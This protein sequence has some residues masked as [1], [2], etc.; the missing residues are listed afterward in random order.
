MSIE[1]AYAALEIPP[2]TIDVQVSSADVVVGVATTVRA[3]SAAQTMGD[4]GQTANAS[5]VAAGTIEISHASLAVPEGANATRD[6]EAA[7]TM[8]DF[9][10]VASMFDPIGTID[11]GGTITDGLPH[12]SLA[13]T[14][15]MAD[16]V[17]SAAA[18]AE[19][20]LGAVSLSANQVMGDFGQ[21]F[22]ADAQRFLSAI[23]TMGDFTQVAQ[24]G[25]PPVVVQPAQTIGTPGY[26]RSR[27]YKTRV[28]SRVL[29]ADTWQ[30][31]RRLVLELEDEPEAKVERKIKISRIDTVADP[32]DTARAEMRAAMKAQLS[33]MQSQMA[34]ML[35]L[36]QQGAQQL[37]QTYEQRLSS[38]E[39]AATTAMMLAQRAQQDSAALAA[40]LT[41]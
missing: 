22:A 33:D 41:E 13:A 27:R 7:Q 15:T 14:Q 17:Q 16:F 38:A 24:I 21:A 39:Q 30:E 31:L 6:L 29:E 2:P 32:V 1:V 11:G 35:A 10:Q 18:G 34:Q 8:D 20:T 40:L 4:F 3:L 5:G 25:D 9:V 12:K 23:Q 19:G 26:E 36:Q 37:A 28:G